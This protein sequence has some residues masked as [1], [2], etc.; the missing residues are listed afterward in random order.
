MMKFKLDQMRKEI[1]DEID[2]DENELHN[3]PP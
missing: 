3:I 2:F 1:S